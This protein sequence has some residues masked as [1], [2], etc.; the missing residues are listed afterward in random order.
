MFEIYSKE[1]PIASHGNFF[2]SLQFLGWFT[3]DTNSDLLFYIELSYMDFI[4]LLSLNGNFFRRGLGPWGPN[5]VRRHS[6]FLYRL[7]PSAGILTED[8]SRLL[9]G[10]G[11]I[12]YNI[13]SEHAL[14]DV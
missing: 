11:K 9:T 7:Y 14:V 3:C 6:N 8:E 2:Y 12:V 5:L 4:I 13:Y 1:L 10:I